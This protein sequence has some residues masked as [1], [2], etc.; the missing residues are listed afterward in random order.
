MDYNFDNLT[1]EEKELLAN[2]DIG[3]EYLTKDTRL[4]WLE[5]AVKRYQEM[6]ATDG[7][8]GPFDV[9]YVVSVLEPYMNILD[10]ARGYNS[11]DE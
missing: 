6:E 2:S 5:K 3:P 1:D 9:I 7:P 4:E 11:D 8:F 10:K